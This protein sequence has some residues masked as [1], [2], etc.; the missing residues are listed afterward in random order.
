MDIKEWD[1]SLFKKIQELMKE[2]DIKLRAD[3]EFLNTDNSIADA[4]FQA[5]FDF[6]VDRGTY[7]ISTGRV[8]KFSEDEVKEALSEAPREVPLGEG[9][10]ARVFKQ[11][12]L[13]TREPINICP[14]HHAPFTVDLADLVVRNFA[15]IPRTDF[16]EGFNFTSV[17]GREVYGIPM[18]AYASRREVAWMREGVRKAGRPGLAIVVYPISTK[19]STLIAALDP[20][21]GLRRTDGVLLSTLPDVQMEYDLLTTAI[22]YHDYGSKIKVNGSFAMAGGFCGGPDGAIIEGIVR[23]IVGWMVYRD[24]VHYTGVEHIAAIS[25]EKILIQPM[26]WARSVVFQALNRN[27]NIV[28]MEWNIPCSELCTEMCLLESAVR[29]IEA[30]LNGA[31]L[32]AHRVS[33]PRM[34]AGQTPLEAEW[35]V[36]VSDATIN[37]GLTRK[38]SGDILG[39]LAKRLHG[40]KPAP[41]KTI[42]EC[43]DLVKHK[44]SKE[45]LEIYQNVK[46]ELADLGLKFE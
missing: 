40:K 45:Y 34:N 12:S 22:V 28:Y 24:T 41:G 44:P 33:R 23:P 42:Q 17:D 16:I 36:E 29:S 10:D 31:N 3:D 11:Q 18:E 46:K 37:A 19:A 1:M 27:T 5:A 25:G 39:T 30:P 14:G 7:C 35:M 2:Y 26:N 32:Y 21:Y 8:V 20:D 4:A 43:Y 9:N 13:D 6:I 38:N 15:Q